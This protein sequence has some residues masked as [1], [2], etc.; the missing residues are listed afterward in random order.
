MSSVP[1]RSEP[2]V[3]PAFLPK[4]LLTAGLGEP[5]GVYLHVPFCAKRCG[6]CDFNTYAPADLGGTFSSGDYLD[7]VTAEVRLAGA[8]LGAPVA[9]TVFIGGGTPTMLEPNQLGI[10]LAAVRGCFA[11]AADAEVTIEAN[12]DSVRP[13]TMPALAELGV[14]RVSLGMQSSQP[15]VLKVLDRTHDPENVERAIGWAA[16]AGLA[17]SLDLIYGTP[18]ET[19][20]DWRASLQAAIALH[21]DHLS[22]YALVVEDGTA[23]ARRVR[24]GEVAAPIDDD[25]ATKYEL[26]DELLQ[27]AGYHW[28]EVSNWSRS[29]EHRCRHN[30]SYWHNGNWWGFGPGAHS[31]VGGVR[32]WNHRHPNRYAAAVRTGQ[33]PVAGHEA[34][35][36]EQRYTELVLL[37]IRLAE[38]LPRRL[39]QPEGQQAVPPLVNDGL[40][41]IEAPEDEA[42]IV[43]TRRGRLLADGVVRRLLDW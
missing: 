4:E 7:A 14:T 37:R 2:A 35:S 21:P 6:Y 32:W 11:L 41:T 3:A 1:G 30:V 24:R 22:A 31:H 39:L 17:T 42:R 10:M 25:Q 5:C 20:A 9:R 40:V 16:E 28:Y 27:A 18:G 19:L 15:H 36:H 23:L 26:A 13:D 38:G 12:P 29:P 34:L 33:L 8:L 43:L